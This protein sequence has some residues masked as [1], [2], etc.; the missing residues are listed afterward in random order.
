MGASPNSRA[1]RQCVLAVSVIEDVDLTPA[2]R[3]VVV[4]GTPPVRIL[5]KYVRRAL[6]GA[7]PEST[8]ARKR[9]AQWLR[10]ARWLADLDRDVLS[11]LARPYGVPVDHPFHPGLDWVRRR[12]LGDALDLGLGFVGLNPA[13]PD[14]VVPVPQGLLE[15]LDIEAGAWWKPA[16]LYLEEMGAVASERWRRQP[17]EPLRPMG[18]CD[19]VT[20]LGSKLFRAAI[21]SS[22]AT[23]MRGVAVPMRTRG[24][25]DLVRIDPAFAAA[26][27]S[28]TEPEHRGFD[29]PLLITSDEVVQAAPGG[30]PAE[31]VLRDPA[32]DSPHLRDVLYR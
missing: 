1:L 16:T 6:A 2:G 27:A 28:A 15:I 8:L 5:W 26:A 22:D 20:L 9:L 4:D 23:G 32:A 11:G 31:I 7:D 12:V 17:H 3:W 24:W 25:M 19:V 10:A 21:A 18:D 29:R 30:R 13:E 14:E